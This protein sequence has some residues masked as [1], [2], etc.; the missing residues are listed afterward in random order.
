MSGVFLYDNVCV[1]V[2]VWYVQELVVYVV[3]LRV[4]V[5]DCMCVFIV[6]CLKNVCPYAL[7][8]C[9]A[10]IVC[11]CVVV[12]GTELI[13]YVLS[14]RFVKLVCVCVDGVCCLQ[15]LVYVLF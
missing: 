13:V 10:R 11:I 9:A 2:V 6:C 3:L 7:L 4:L 15:I 14:L 12:E 8:L 1:C 5:I